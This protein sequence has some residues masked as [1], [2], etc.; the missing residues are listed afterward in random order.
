MREIP[1]TRGYEA[2]VDDEDYERVMAAGPWHVHFG[3]RGTRVAVL[4]ACVG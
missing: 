3:P 2:I 1:L 4:K